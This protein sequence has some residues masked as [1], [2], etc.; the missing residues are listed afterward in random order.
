MEDVFKFRNYLFGGDIESMLEYIKLG[1]S[2]LFRL[3]KPLNKPLYV[4]IDTSGVCNLKCIM[5]VQNVEGLAPPSEK[6]KFLPIEVVEK[7]YEQVC[8]KILILGSVGEPLLNKDIVEFLKIATRNKSKTLM[9]TNGL[10]LNKEMAVKLVDN[11]IHL[12]KISI[13]AA[14]NETYKKI[15][16]S[17][18]FE[19]LIQNIKDLVEIEKD[20]GKAGKLVRLEFVIQH[21]NIHEIIPFIRMAK[22]LGVSNVCFFPLHFLVFGQIEDFEKK[23][24]SNYSLQEIISI[25]FEAKK[26]A[27]ELGINV[28]LHEIL[29]DVDKMKDLKSDENDSYYNIF[30]WHKYRLESFVCIEP[31]FQLYIDRSGDVTICCNGV[32]YLTYEK[33]ERELIF[34]NINNGDNLLDIWQSKKLQS[35]RKICASRKNLGLF[36]TCSSCPT[37]NFIQYEIWKNKLFPF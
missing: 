4:N 1:I 23:F 31:W 35:F 7:L 16:Q 2:L 19:K 24:K 26:V 15:R 9:T 8:P 30:P 13:D 32:D 22:D 28:N 5:C 11:G 27:K 3:K 17:N 36:K 25:L 6:E 14:T 12:I 29:R 37:R 18:D 20:R 10:L 33:N 21:G 34:G